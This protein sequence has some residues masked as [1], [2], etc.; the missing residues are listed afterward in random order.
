[1]FTDMAARTMRMGRP[2]ARKAH[3][4]SG[5]LRLGEPRAATPTSCKTPA[6][7]ALNMSEMRCRAALNVLEGRF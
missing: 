6:F 4:G 1:M 7:L 3:L 5:V 2:S